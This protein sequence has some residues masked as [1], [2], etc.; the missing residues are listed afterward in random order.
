M[1]KENLP[2]AQS[3]KTVIPPPTQLSTPNPLL[4]EQF[5]QQRFGGYRTRVDIPNA[6]NVPYI[7]PYANV[8]GSSSPNTS[9]LANLIKNAVTPGDMGGGGRLRTLDEFAANEKGRYDYFMPGNFDNEDAAAQ[10]QSWGA[11][12]VNGVGKGLLLTGTT[13]LQ[14]T[15]GLVNG[16]YQA[17]ADGKFS[18]FYDNEFN[19]ALDEINKSAEDA[20]PNYYTAKERNANWYSPNYWMTGNFL[21]DGVVVKNLGF[22]AGAALSGG[23]YTSTLKALP[24]ASRLFSVGKAAETLA[25]TEAGIASGVGKAAETYGKIRGLSDKFL[26]NYNT[27]NPA[28]RFVVAGL[29][30]TG[31][32]GIEALHSSNEFRQKLIDEHIEQYGVEPTGGALQSINDAVEGAGNATF[33]ANV[34]LLTAT[35]YIQF[36]KILGSTYKGEKGIVNGLVREIDDIVYE[37]GK[38]VKPK[39]KYPF[40]SKINKI[41]PYTF[42]TSEAFEEVSQYSATVATQD[43]YEKA[44]NGEA[45][46]WLNSVGVGITKGAFSNEGA[47]NALIGGISGRLMTVGLMPGQQG[48]IQQARAKRKN[49][50]EA[51]EALNNTS[52]SDFTKETIDSVNRGTVLQQ[53]REAAIKSGDIL[54]S[55]DLEKDY[56]IN[57]LTPRIKYGRYDLVKADINEYRKLASTEEG[58][59]QLVAEGKALETDTREAYLERLNRFEQTADNVKSLWQSLNLRYSGELD[60]NGKPVY[61]NDVMNKMIYAA[62][63]VADYDQRMLDLM[64]PLTAAGI[65]TTEVMQQ[66]LDGN[67]EAFNEAVANIKAMDILEEDKETLAQSLEDTSELVLRRQSFLQAYQDIKENPSKYRA[68]PEVTQEA[69]AGPVET[70]TVKTKRGERD[71]ELGTPYFVGRGVDYSKDPLDKA[72]PISEFTVQKVNE[73]GTLEV[74][75][76]DGQIK[77]ISPDVLEDLNIGKVS[78]LTSDKTANFYY[79]HRNEIFEFNFG[80]N[81]GGK[82]RGRLEYQDGK[83]YFTH[84]TPKGKVARK[85]VNNSYFLAQEDYAQPRITKVGS[86]ENQQQREAR[87]QFMSAEEIARQKAT[88]AKNREARLEAL[89]QLGEEAKESLEETNKKLAQQTEKLAK[90]KEDLEN[91]AKMK[92]AGPTGPKIKLNFSKVTRVFTKALNNLTAMQADIEAEIDNLNTQKEE[93][94]LNISYF[95]DF[96]NQITDAPEDSGAFLQELKNQVALLLD[97]GK[98]L[99]N[100]LSAAKKLAKSTEKAIK[101]AAS[102]FRKTLKETYIVDQDYSQYLSDLL[103]QVISGEN[104]QETWPLLKQEMANFA[105]TS[106]LS[107]DATVNEA[108]LLNSISDV[109]QIEKDL[110]DLKAEYKARKI[111]V[112]RFQK[113]A[114][115]YATKKAEEEK[116][117]RDIKAT[118][119]L[120]STED[121][122]V[123]LDDANQVST[124]EADSKKADNIIPIATKPVSSSELSETDVDKPHQIRANRFGINLPNLPK[125]VRDGIR[126]VFVTYDTQ[127][128]V[129][130]AENGK[131]VV[132]LMLEDVSE[133]RLPELRASSIIMLMVDKDGNPVDENGNTIPSGETLLDKIVFQVMPNEN[134]TNKEKGTGEPVSMFRSS[135]DTTVKEAITQQYKNWRDGVI[136]EG[137]EGNLSP[138]VTIA[139]SFGQ[140]VGDNNNFTPSQDAGLISSVDLEK[141]NL[142]F[143]PKFGE[144]VRTGEMEYKGASGGAFL[145]LPDGRAAVRLKNRKHTEQ[146]A[147]V[148]ADAIIQLAKNRMEPNGMQSASSSRLLSFLQSVVYWG[149]PTDQQGKVKATSTNS[150]FFIKDREDGILKLI[151]SNDGT[152]YKFTPSELQENREAI[153]AKLSDM[154]NNATSAKLGDVNQE[155]VQITAVSENGEIESVTWPNYQTYLLSNKNNKGTGSRTNPPLAVTLDPDNGIDMNRKGIYFYRTDSSDD[156][157]PVAKE[158]VEATEAQQGP[159]NIPL[160]KNNYVFDGTTE[161]IYQTADNTIPFTVDSDINNTNYLQKINVNLDKGTAE[162]VINKRQEAGESREQAIVALKKTIYQNISPQLIESAQAKQTQAEDEKAKKLRSIFSKKIETIAGKVVGKPIDEDVKP[163]K[164]PG[165][166][167]RNRESL[168]VAVEN[169]S[170][171]FDPENW[172]DV[173]SWLKQN[174]PNVPVY[175]V[176]N[177]IQ[178]TNGRQAWGMFK[179]G[180]IY[181]YENAEVGTT[182]HEVFEA[183]YS[184]FV[185]ANEKTKLNEEFK[186]RTGTFV[187]RPTGKSVKY[188]EATPAQIKEQLAEEFRDYIQYKKI[189]PKPKGKNFITRLFADIKSFIEKF[190]LGRDAKSNTEELFAK[191]GEGY[192]AKNMPYASQL[193]L[194]QEG[195]LD[196]NN[197]DNTSGAEFRLNVNERQRDD[198]VN[199]MLYITLLELTKSNATLFEASKLDKQFFDGLQ[200]NVYA[201]VDN[202]IEVALEE[203][204]QD[205]AAELLALKQNI[206]DEWSEISKLYKERVLQ[207]DVVFDEEDSLISEDRGRGDTYQE[208]TKIDH[209]RKAKKGIKLLMA[210]LPMMDSTIY[211][212]T[213]AVEEKASSIGGAILLP[214]GRVYTTLMERLHDSVN[215]T[216][217]VSRLRKLAEDDINY[218]SL[219]K[220]VTKRSYVDRSTTLTN[221]TEP[222]DAELI[223]GLWSMVKNQS[224]NAKNVIIFEDGTSTVANSAMSTM[225]DQ[226]RQKYLNSIISLA[227]SG[228]GLFTYNKSNNT[229]TSDKNKLARYSVVNTD[230]QVKFLEALGIPFTTSEIK[231]I[232]TNESVFRKFDEAARG[233]YNSLAKLG[234]LK[235][236]SSSELNMSNRLLEVAEV[237][238]AI[239]NP[240]RSSTFFIAGERRQSYIGVNA[241]SEI[242][243]YISKVEYL[244]DLANSPYAYLLTDSFSKYSNILSRLFASD[245]SRKSTKRDLLGIG[246]L[247]EL[248]DKSKGKQKTP[249]RFTFKERLVSMFNLQQKGIFPVLVPGDASLEYT[250]EMGTPISTDNLD[251]I[252]PIFKGYFLSEVELSREDRPI[253]TVEGRNTTDLRFFKDIL[254]NK[255]HSD[256][257]SEIQKDETVSAD[258]IYN[259]YEDEINTYVTEFILDKVGEYRKLLEN[260]KVV[261]QNVDDKTG[262]PLGTYK[263]EG[264]DVSQNLSEDALTDTLIAN[265]ANYMIANI[266]MHKLLFS[267]PYQYKGDE[268]KRIK[269]FLSTREAIVNQSVEV[270]TLLNQ[271]W[272]KGFEKGDI[273]YTNFTQ[274]HF[275]TASHQDIKVI[276]NLPGHGVHKETDGSGIIAFKAHRN[277][278]IRTGNWNQEEEKQYRY[279]VAWEKRDKNLDLSSEEQELLKKGNPQI[280]SAFTPSKPIVS[281]AKLG[282]TY[283]NVVLEK[284]ALYP[285]SYRVMKE[286]NAESNLVKLYNKMQDE[287]IDYIVFESGRKVGAESSHA[288]YNEDGSFNDSEYAAVVKVPFNIISLQ[289]DVPSKDEDQVIKA[290]QPT[291]LVTLD[292]LDNGVPEDFETGKNFDD[293]YTAWVQLSEAEKLEKSDLHKEYVNNTQLLNKMSEVGLQSVLKKLGIVE[294]SDGTYVV[295]DLSTATK[296]LREELFKRETNNNISKALDDFLAG[297]S[298][299]EITPAYQQIRNIL[300]SIADKQIS[301]RKITGG[302]KVQISSAGFESNR[303]AETEIN[304]KKGYTSDVLG[305]YSLTKDGKEVKFL[306]DNKNGTYKVLTEEGKEVN[307]PVSDLKTTTMEVMIGR[308]FESNMSD[309]ELLDYLNNTPEGQKIL[310]GFAFRIPTQAQ[311]SID[312]FRIKQFLPKEFGDSVVVPASI[313]EK[314][315]SDFDIDKLFMYFKSVYI[316]KN[317]NLKMIPFYGLDEKVAKKKFAEMYDRG[318]LLTK[319]QMDKIKDKMAN[320]PVDLTQEL[321][322]K[323][324]VAIFGEKFDKDQAALE[325][326]LT[327][328][329][330]EDIKSKLVDKAFIQSIENEYIQSLENLV[331][332]PLNFKRLTR[333]NS[334]AQL[335]KIADDIA[336]KV[337]GESFDYSN[338]GNMLDPVFMYRLRQ[339][340]L[341][342]KKGIG[343]AAVNQTFKS[344]LQKIPVFIDPSKIANQKPQDRPYLGDGVIRFKEYNTVTIDGKKMASLSGVTNAKDDLISNINGQFTDGYVDISN[345]PWIILMGA[346]PNVASTFL[347][348]NNLGV[349]IEQVAYFMNQPIIRDY[350]ELIDANGYSWLFIDNYVN[351]IKN[352]PAYKINPEVNTKFKTIPDNLL[353]TVGKKNLNTLERAQQHFMLDE[354]LKYAKMASQAFTLN[355]GINWDT[356]RFNDPLLITRKQVKLEEARNTIFSTVGNV[357]VADAL[358]NDTFLGGMVSALEQSRNALGTLIP[359]DE[360]GSNI[361]NTIQEVIEP[362]ARNIFSEDDF[363]KVARKLVADVFDYA[364]QTNENLNTE[365]QSILLDKNGVVAQAQSF[366]KEVLSNEDHPMFDNLI[367]RSLESSPSREAGNTPNNLMIGST[368]NKTYDQNN[369]IYSFRELRDYLEGR[370]SLYDDIVQ[371]SI[372]Q[373]G[374]SPSPI[375]FTALIP[376]EDVERIYGKVLSNLGSISNLVEFKSL[377]VFERN[378]W[379]NSDIV[380]QEKA[381]WIRNKE[382]EWVYNPQMRYLPDA[383]Q[384][385]KAI[386]KQNKETP[387][388]EVIS[389]SSTSRNGNSDYVFFSWDN[390]QISKAKRKEMRDKGDFSYI[391]RGLF[392]KI[393]DAD[394]NPVISSGGYFYYK[395]INAWGDGFRAK[396]FY[397]LSRQSVIDNGTLKVENEM[398]DESLIPFLRSTKRASRFKTTP[399]LESTSTQPTQPTSEVLNRDIIFDSAIGEQVALDASSQSWIKKIDESMAIS[400]ETTFKK[401]GFTYLYMDYMPADQQYQKQNLSTGKVISEN[402]TKEEYEEARG[403]LDDNPFR[404]EQISFEEAKRLYERSKP[405]EQNKPEGLPAIDRTSKKC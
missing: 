225:S 381:R 328:T 65:N 14:S 94:E 95:Q 253:A 109:K 384:T 252:L 62:T 274:D 36:P 15:V 176:K 296:T 265:Q 27:L 325:D 301:K 234:N 293:R 378:N 286:I 379:R 270:N 195:I 207:Y 141:N 240:N 304:G 303:V 106:D 42:S 208:A 40:L 144:P 362:Y 284:F 134:L 295:E 143:I 227:K 392:Q 222:H 285:L 382:D 87:E 104:L 60:E 136:A 327:N 66:L 121:K 92:E 292:Y 29:S 145:I 219:Y 181:V 189:P 255:L 319:K 4:N 323:M 266:E 343:I 55:K 177:I 389:I 361:R 192:Y 184:M 375:S 242:A 337:Y 245:G 130:P 80:K 289:Q 146:E 341:S 72:I 102:L 218:R 345:G 99:N 119:Q 275:N 298:N 236:L 231:T 103:D 333:P 112:D 354:F 256:I 312:V 45:T 108:D 11:Q 173:E 321:T 202:F 166:T 10:G 197:V 380:P 203:D 179:D 383:Y 82:K 168:R 346:S 1:A 315:G 330:S 209:F 214:Q 326:Y 156:F 310:S 96:A 237:K 76:Q 178:A 367:V 283:N 280:K 335:E 311:N 398:S 287:N 138:R 239:N 376:Y 251:S 394:G 107:K 200:E 320:K 24:Y 131:S 377:G 75:T 30:T 344:Q 314:V 331:T 329:T 258:A 161:N 159:R 401:D 142:I 396:E 372:L 260:Y 317:G 316:D 241:L 198:V 302:Q 250:A 115:E 370:T 120:M 5:M 52:L 244:S 264:V 73:D 133:E 171:M 25:A 21:W 44:R 105:L 140:P 229:Y 153:V 299:L 74:R 371:L 180:A 34:G 147:N 297:K 342:G 259:K 273:G 2:K 9:S 35:N 137:K 359:S 374:V 97:N 194:A 150:V 373:S 360:E 48:M 101:S 53:E 6:P 132:D 238:A 226:I 212:K 54:N 56:I 405:T 127:N 307:I 59:A 111:I 39:T 90:I 324:I 336:I 187:D 69:P 26:S 100:A 277:F 167:G 128:L 20:L 281:G 125:K 22:A 51:I 114:D 110:A 33:F 230:T 268:L 211:A 126:G 357:D 155:F 124:Y 79:N 16:T 290:S 7:N 71:V 309:K 57:Y 158:V 400:G 278:R 249:G 43:Y 162:S 122:G 322:D 190:F 13:F 272:N 12:M 352:R 193:S 348:L 340:F 353:N 85:E 18:S 201:T 64:G 282:Y 199:E 248:A 37:G 213:G 93:L 31:E 224:P 84:L 228:K 160:A 223:T 393:K 50:A 386:A 402:I 269:S 387:Y 152:K 118:E 196:I 188:S 183:V 395:Q 77:N 247:G 3:G 390:M 148:I 163:K 358:I 169:S 257:V 232:K 28:G 154:Y 399:F 403:N 350:L 338:V 364:V 254:G 217:M 191:I 279:E 165:S 157:T 288:T 164:R 49:T 216:D 313:V 113:I 318:E 182:Y 404:V 70:V 391:N 86:V 63:K 339:A 356:S 363:I 41:R 388:P 347:F 349:P 123:A 151:L 235:Y 46:S 47:K 305:F 205:L 129:V 174:F 185:D 67:A 81:F 88:L 78:T 91:I 294:K 261:E 263:M 365:I 135:T 17:I 149:I 98:N 243:N 206:K 291:K 89:T 246:Y 300:Y 61:D 334:A 233:M 210:T 170:K 276:N 332:N 19:R 38:Y 271:V 368:D 262:K 220:R 23:V 366:I 8:Q 83:L 68:A 221:L 267:D 175:R 139:A 32:A 369:I 385:V 355:Q 306:E 397:P 116:L 172:T 117:L 308:W 186:S 215:P 58:F 351:D 204:N